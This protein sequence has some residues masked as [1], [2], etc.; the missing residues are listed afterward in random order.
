MTVFAGLKAL[1]NLHSQNLHPTREHI[2]GLI[3]T[4]GLAEYGPSFQVSTGPKL[5][6]HYLASVACA[7]W[8]TSAFICLPS[9]TSSPP[10][11]L[12]TFTWIDPFSGT[13]LAMLDYDGAK[14]EQ[15][16]GCLTPQLLDSTAHMAA[17]L[18]GHESGIVM[19]NGGFEV[20]PRS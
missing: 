20:H 9:N 5:L 16:G 13:F 4:P 14:W 12:A 19:Y 6:S 2:Y 18:S 17:C 3:N 8:L 15:R 10:C 1:I 11:Q 7:Y